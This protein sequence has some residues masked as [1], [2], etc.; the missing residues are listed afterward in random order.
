MAL[1]S[2]QTSLINQMLTALDMQPRSS[3]AVQ[4]QDV[5]TALRKLATM[6]EIPNAQ[7][8]DPQSLIGPLA[9]KMNEMAQSA[10]FRE[11]VDSP[12]VPEAGENLKRQIALNARREMGQYV[13]SA[14]INNPQLLI[15]LVNNREKLAGA[16]RAAYGPASA[17]AAVTPPTIPST[18]PVVP[19]MSSHGWRPGMTV[20]E[21][22]DITQSRVT[23][24]PAPA[25]AS[26]HA[27]SPS[28]PPVNID[29]VAE[30]AMK[31]EIALSQI[32]PF[33][34]REISE[35]GQSQDSPRGALASLMSMFSGSISV[36]MP[37][38]IDGTFDEKSQKSLAG[39]LGA[40]AGAMDIEW[41]GPYTPELGRLILT[42]YDAHKDKFERFGDR[43]S[44]ENIEVLITQIDILH[45]KKL[46]PE[47]IKPLGGD[48]PFGI[49]GMLSGA[50][51]R[52]TAEFPS[53][54][55]L[56]APIKGFLEAI[57]NFFTGGKKPEAEAAKTAEAESGAA[58]ES[59]DAAPAPSPTPAPQVAATS[60]PAVAPAAVT[61]TPAFNQASSGNGAA[62]Q[63]EPAVATTTTR[64]SQAETLALFDFV[65]EEC[66]ASPSAC[67]PAADG[68]RPSAG[69][70][71]P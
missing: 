6:M 30:A 38:A 8:A 43:A 7:S 65:R 1:T 58:E 66:T 20:P 54:G 46:V 63:G 53:W 27:E 23:P 5:D 29:P 70:A 51:D 10:D 18:P 64:L 13:P 11:F 21:S 42:N 9:I 67:E 61:P 28:A 71:R 59:A 35:R 41:E 22:F 15:D 56:L 68:P 48:S 40:V 19:M 33:I 69:P 4:Q 26:Y 50:L 34:N 12:L 55:A 39:V 44:K 49:F 45:G 3:G 60:E 25:P 36:P 2:E 52:I 62:P 17:P 47:A 14:L 16:A 32:V 37:G 31:V 57:M 24:P